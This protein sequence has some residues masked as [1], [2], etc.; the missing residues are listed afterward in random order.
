MQTAPHET[1]SFDATY[2]KAHD[3]ETDRESTTFVSKLTDHL[4]NKLNAQLTNNNPTTRHESETD[5]NITVTVS[6]LTGHLGNRQE[7]TA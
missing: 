3:A 5:Q 6:H 2:R 1:L 4:G 7:A